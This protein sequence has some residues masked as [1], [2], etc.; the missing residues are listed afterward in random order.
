MYSNSS[1][2]PPSVNQWRAWWRDAK[3]NDTVSSYMNSNF[4][5]KYFGDM[6]RG[7][8]KYGTPE[9]KQRIAAFRRHLARNKNP[10]LSRP[11]WDE[12]RRQIFY[13]Y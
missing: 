10:N 9:Q 8:Y 11:E 1:K 3:W 4:D 7:W 6:L 12:L 5:M 13:S 2:K